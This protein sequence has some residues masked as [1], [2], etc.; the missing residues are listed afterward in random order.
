MSAAR[1][2]KLRDMLLIAG[3]VELRLHRVRRGRH[4]TER[5]SRR[6]DLDDERFHNGGM[7]CVACSKRSRHG[8]GTR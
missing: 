7:A 3:A 1:P 5:Q 6:E 2:Q 4:L 8:T